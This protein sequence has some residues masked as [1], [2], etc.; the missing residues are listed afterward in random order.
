MK[1][2]LRQPGATSARREE[3][4]VVE[5][6]LEGAQM[7]E[8]SVGRKYSRNKRLIHRARARAREVYGRV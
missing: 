5:R 8:A 1:I 4:R 7:P 2:Y 3:A 6:S